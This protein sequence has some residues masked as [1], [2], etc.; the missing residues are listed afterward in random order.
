MWNYEINGNKMEAN[1]LSY[2][3]QLDGDIVRMR[4]TPSSPILRSE[5]SEG[6]NILIK[7]YT[8]HRKEQSFRWL[9]T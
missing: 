6:E 8:V 5:I 7:N 9:I 2:W 4:G 1:A 3:G